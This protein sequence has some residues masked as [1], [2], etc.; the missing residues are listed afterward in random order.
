MGAQQVLRAAATG[1]LI[2]TAIGRAEAAPRWK[3]GAV[4]PPGERRERI[5]VIDLG[6]TDDAATRG[7]SDVD[8]K[9]LA[10]YPDVDA[11]SDRE[12]VELDVDAD[13]PGAALW[14]DFAPAGT[15]PAH[16]TLIAGEHV[17]AAASGSRRGTITGTAVK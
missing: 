9:L 14:V 2:A 7:S 10:K 12:L 8:A 4:A 11:I 1:L 15:A 6:P 3:A 5:A 17:I 13:A 16:L